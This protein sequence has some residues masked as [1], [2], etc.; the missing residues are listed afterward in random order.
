MNILM[1]LLVAYLLLDRTSAF[2][3]N[4]EASDN[5]SDLQPLDSSDSAPEPASSE[6]DDTSSY[7][8]I[9]MTSPLQPPNRK[10]QGTKNKSN[11]TSRRKDR[12]GKASLD[13][14]VS[15]NSLFNTL[16]FKPTPLYYCRSWVSGIN[17][18]IPS[19]IT[20]PLAPTHQQSTVVELT[21]FFEDISIQSQPA[22][23]CYAE[24]STTK[25]TW[26]FFGSEQEQRFKEKV[27]VSESHCR[28]LIKSKTAPNGDKLERI[29]DGFFGTSRKANPRWKW[30]QT[31]SDTVI[32]YYFSM[33]TMA[34]SSRDNSIQAP[35]KLLDNCIDS[36][37]SCPTELGV[38]V[39]TPRPHDS[40]CRLKQGTTTS[41]LKTGDRISCPEINV[42]VTHITLIR[43]CSRFLGNSAQGLIFT[44]T[45]PNTIHEM[46]ATTDEILPRINRT[47]TR[48]DLDAKLETTFMPASQIQGQFTF[49][50]DMV[51]SNLT[52]A[53]Q[54]LHSSVC[55]NNQILLDLLR[56][57]AAG[58]SPSLLLQA[59]L[60]ENHY[61]AALSGD[62]LSV[63][64]CDI[65]HNYMFQPRTDCQVEWP[66]LFLHNHDQKEGFLTPLSHE[67]VD[68]ATPTECPAGQFFFDTGS[69]VVLLNNRSIKYDLPTLPRPGDN[70]EVGNI[71][72][73]S[74]ASPGV[75]TAAEIS[76]RETLLAL[77][78]DMKN[79]YRVDDYLRAYETGSHYSPGHHQIRAAFQKATLSP[80]KEF[81]MQ[82]FLIIL[83]VMLTI[84]FLNYLYGRGLTPG[85]VLHFIREFNLRVFCRRA[86]H[87]LRRRHPRPYH[88]VELN[89]LITN[90]HQAIDGI[91]NAE[92]H[93]KSDATLMLP[94]GPQPTALP[95]STDIP[96]APG[97]SESNNGL[98][99]YPR[100]SIKGAVNAF[101]QLPQFQ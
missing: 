8:I 29:S 79:N 36:I 85:N 90:A 55:R 63:F 17:W 52:F 15:I 48:R 88:E 96:T 83:T 74:F 31:D 41:C 4:D 93:Y 21:F 62:I 101:H 37:G 95:T 9:P 24:E 91:N 58:G 72:E 22:Y 23:E 60:G 65:I 10:R 42:A 71:P 38:L 47:R 26:Y 13:E 73:L 76:G 18:K 19:R 87:G 68:T 33:L 78:R 34:I 66:V 27:H 64:K 2:P 77:L 35:T 43:L 57:L 5:T 45:L 39:W 16:D 53:I 6:K 67:I 30:P 7:S 61:R 80:M 40:Q 94:N 92:V 28:D 59:L 46:I 11:R 20:C 89:T 49:L 86:R 69:H 56:S 1:T 81:L 99:L 44:Q 50:W 32:N 70:T 97:A 25:L 100:S 75:Y 3:I 14:E 84:F 82:I 12:R 98:P 54:M 51:R